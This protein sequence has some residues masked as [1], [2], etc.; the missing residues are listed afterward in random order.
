MPRGEKGERVRRAP[1]DDAVREAL[2]RVMKEAKHVRSQKKLLSM[3]EEEL[4]KMNSQWGITPKRLRRL[5]AE[6]PGVKI[7]S[8]CRTS[9]AGVTSNIC[10]VC[11]GEMRPVKNQTL[12]GWRVTSGYSCPQCGYWTGKRRRV[13][14]LYEFILEED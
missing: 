4:R 6:T 3:V 7:I 2:L 12:Y 9:H 11:G 8:Y 10:P 5:T 14:T 13:P 1:P